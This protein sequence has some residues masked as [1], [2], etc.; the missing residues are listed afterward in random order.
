MPTGYTADVCDGKVTDFKEFAMRC[1][2]NFGALIM[3]RDDA[4]DAPI[5]EFKPSEYEREALENAKAE[6][7]KVQGMT[8]DECTAAAL[9]EYREALGAHQKVEA[10]RLAVR[11]RLLAMRSKVADWRPPTTDHQGLKDFMIEQ[12][13][14]TIGSDGAPS[15]YYLDKA[16]KLSGQDWR[17]KEL[18]SNQRRV[19]YYTDEYAKEV[20]RTNGRNRWVKELRISLANQV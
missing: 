13:D 18:A 10:E 20:E 19:V 4:M 14:M 2:R 1:A 3:M 15:T 9:G 17:A 16:K 12:L 7:L 5:P 11:G 8:D 6:L